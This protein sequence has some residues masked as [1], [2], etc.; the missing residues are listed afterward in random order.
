MA[1]D[2]DR[3]THGEA[4]HRDLSPSG[5]GPPAGTDPIAEA[6]RRAAERAGEG[7]GLIVPDR[8]GDEPV[9]GWRVWK[10]FVDDCTLRSSLYWDVIWPR[11]E[12]MKATCANVTHLG[13]G[14]PSLECTCGI[15]SYKDRADA[16][17]RVLAWD[18]GAD[19]PVVYRIVVMGR[20]SL[21]GHLIEHE[22][23]WR[24]S[25]A[26]P[27]DIMIPKHNGY[28]YEEMAARLRNS[29]RVDA[30]AEDLL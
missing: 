6:A 13:D 10:L 22:R 5:P 30:T 25:R 19:W 14:H 11:G 27:Y 28:D 8:F 20:V 29:Y 12:E 24:A 2:A 23:G 3:Q 7:S 15:W 9:Y 1:D 18:G 26:Y 17:E 4:S 16:L 21:W